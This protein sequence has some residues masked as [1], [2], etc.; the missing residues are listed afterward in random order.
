MFTEFT[1]LRRKDFLEHYLLMHHCSGGRTR[2]VTHDLR[3][4]YSL[5]C[6]CVWPQADATG[7]QQLKPADATGEQQ[8]K[9]AD[10]TGE[11]QLKTD[12]IRERYSQGVKTSEAHLC[13]QWGENCHVPC[14]ANRG[15]SST[16]LCTARELQVLDCS[17]RLM[18]GVVAEASGTSEYIRLHMTWLAKV[19]L[20]HLPLSILGGILCTCNNY[21]HTPAEIF[22]RSVALIIIIRK[23]LNN[24]LHMKTGRLLL[25]TMSWC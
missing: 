8:L 23:L 18:R 25:L 9:P 17:H 1:S 5:H 13:L 2:L 21:S 14:C 12:T 24:R 19:N 6:T 4:F 16:D 22:M 3:T 11:Q 10:A 15:E 7:K 20:G